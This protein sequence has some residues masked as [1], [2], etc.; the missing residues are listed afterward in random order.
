MA[1]LV[2]ALTDAPLAVSN[3]SL[4]HR[5]A[6]CSRRVTMA[7]FGHTVLKQHHVEIICAVCFLKKEPVRPKMVPALWLRGNDGSRGP[8]SGRGVNAWLC[9]FKNLLKNP[10][11]NSSGSE[12]LRRWFYERGDDQRRPECSVIYRNDETALKSSGVLDS[13]YVW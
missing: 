3:S 6:L 9:S 7:P 1:R 13:F 2:C 5:C 12:H 8:S 4:E 11:W 10:H